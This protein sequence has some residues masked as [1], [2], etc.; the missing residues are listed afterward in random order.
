MPKNKTL[1]AWALI[2]MDGE[3]LQVEHG[4]QSNVGVLNYNICPIK[5]EAQKCRKHHDCEWAKVVPIE[6]KILN[7]KNKKPR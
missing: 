7:T 6:I 1:K 2:S 3:I 5:K 4:N